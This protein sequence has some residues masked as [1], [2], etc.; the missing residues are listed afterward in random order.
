MSTPDSGSLLSSRAEALLPAGCFAVSVPL[1]LYPLWPGEDAGG[2]VARRAAEFSSGRAAARLAMERAGLPPA[3]IPKSADRAPVWPEGVVG[4]ISHSDL[5]CLAA[6]STGLRGLGL[7]IEP[8]RAF[9]P[10]VAA[11]VIGPDD[12]V[13]GAG[14]DPGLLIFCAKEAV[15]KAQYPLT[16]RLFGPE[17]LAVQIRGTQFHAQFREDVA[18]VVTGAEIEGRIALCAGHVLAVASI[19]N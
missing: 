7:D 4:S 13:E 18:P 15:Y 11:L 9:D 6:V 16:R 2:M 12:L 10:G 17:A 5:A 19:P 1:A 8:L 14:A 3:A